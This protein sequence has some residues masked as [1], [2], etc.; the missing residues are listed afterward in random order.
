MRKYIGMGMACV[1]LFFS[2]LVSAAAPQA[3]LR[4][5][6]PGRTHSLTLKELRAKLPL[7]SLTVDDPVYKKQ[8]KTYEGFWLKDV[9]KLGGVGQA[10]GDELV[11]KC[12]DGYSPTVPWER[13]SEG[14]ALLAFREKGRKGGWE[15]FVQGKS[16]MTPAPFY[17][18]WNSSEKQ[19]PW[20]YQLV[21]IE[22]VQFKQ[23]YSRIFPEGQVGDSAVFR[24]F[25]VF[26]NQCMR[27]H[28]INLQGGEL[29]PELNVP[30]SITEYWDETFLREFIR[31]PGNFRL[32]SKMPPFPDLSDTDLDHLLSYLRWMKDRKNS[33]T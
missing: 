24:G 29:G 27:C 9:L 5:E 31:N 33:G 8:K 25:N 18:V 3:E 20:P 22:V 21:G 12:L 2:V 14:Q 15:S 23:K 13:L 30:R 16:R 1:S 28:S 26:R 19:F 10:G 32:R 4:L 17:L 11:F 6:A 7:A